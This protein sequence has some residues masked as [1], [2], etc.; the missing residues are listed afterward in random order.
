M[1]RLFPSGIR[2]IRLLPDISERPMWDLD[3]LD[4]LSD[5]RN[6]STGM[7]PAFMQQ[8]M[9]NTVKLRDKH[10]FS[11]HLCTALVVRVKAGNH[12][13]DSH[14]SCGAEM[15]KHDPRCPLYHIIANATPRQ[16]RCVH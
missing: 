10:S 6:V 9:Y 4:A 11:G 16:S 15:N 12:E 8:Y 13:E 1:T 3:V 2:M 14:T 7:A 5:V